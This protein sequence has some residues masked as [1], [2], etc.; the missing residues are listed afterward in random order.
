MRIHQK[1]NSKKGNAR[2]GSVKE[3]FTIV[4]NNGIAKDANERVTKTIVKLK[5]PK[6]KGLKTL[7]GFFYANYHIAG[8]GKIV[9][10]K[11]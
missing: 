9:L 4:K 1:T 5:P 10:I 7:G 11:H 6:E 3:T 2:R 8:N